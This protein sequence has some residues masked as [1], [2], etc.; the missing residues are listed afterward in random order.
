MDFLVVKFDNANL[1]L[2]PPWA[3]AKRRVAFRRG[4]VWD[5]KAVMNSKH[6]LPGGAI[7]LIIAFFSPLLR[8]QTVSVWLTTDDQQKLLQPQP[9]TRFAAATGGAAPTLV[10][11]ERAAHQTIEGFG[12]SMT[13]SSAY[14]LNEVV[15]AAS[16]PAVMRALFDHSQGIGVSFLRNP[17]G[18]SDL[19]RTAYSYDDKSGGATDPNLDSFSIAHDQADILPLLVMARSIN[20]QIKMMSRRYLLMPTPNTRNCPCSACGMITNCWEE[21]AK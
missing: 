10:I 19:S 13:D 6:W 1:E 14:L 8:A 18:A 2:D 9:S 15:P 16:L 7:C 20:P 21:P 4:A 17:M 12:A 5:N 3:A 11:D